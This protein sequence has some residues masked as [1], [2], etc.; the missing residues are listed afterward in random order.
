[1]STTRSQRWHL[2]GISPIHEALIR[3]LAKEECLRW[4]RD[5]SILTI[6]WSMSARLDHLDP[7]IRGDAFD[8]VIATDRSLIDAMDDHST[9]FPLFHFG[10]LNPACLRLVWYGLHGGCDKLACVHA[11]LANGSITD[12]SSLQSWVRVLVRCAESAPMPTHPLVA[13]WKT[14]T[15]HD[16]V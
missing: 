14:S 9:T 12:P 1:M 2:I 3:R 13:G 10:T 6:A 8:V 4:S 5:D 7:W 11:S 15:I 16:T